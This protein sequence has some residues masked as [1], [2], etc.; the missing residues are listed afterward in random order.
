MQELFYLKTQ[1][2]QQLQQSSNA[3]LMFDGPSTFILKFIFVL[4]SAGS[5]TA[6]ASSD[7][8]S[9]VIK[10]LYT[11]QSD[12]KKNIHRKMH[13]VMPLKQKKFL[14]VD[15]E[16]FI[17]KNTLKKKILTHLL[18]LLFCF[19]MYTKYFLQESSKRYEDEQKKPNY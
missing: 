17:Y 10:V 12:L 9:K 11:K 3:L 6:I 14:S 13:R 5:V 16:E 2:Q 7:S 18:F 19:E 4:Q 1:L 15:Y 8:S